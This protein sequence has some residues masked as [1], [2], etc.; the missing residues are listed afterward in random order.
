MKKSDVIKIV[1]GLN[2]AG[3]TVW[4]D[5]GWCVD[6]LVG[7]S[8][9]EHGDLDIAVRHIDEKPVRDWLTAKGFT[10]RPSSDKS[11][12]NYVLGNDVG[13]LV[14]IHVFGFDHEGKHIY[15]VKYPSESLTGRATLGGVE[16]RCIAPEWMFR[17]KTGYAPAPKDIVDVYALAEKYGY[18]IPRTHRSS[19]TFRMA[20]TADLD[21]IMQ[22]DNLKRLEHINKAVCHGE[23]YVA[24][25]N[26]KI[27]GF[28]IL[29][30]KFFEYGF[31]ELLIIAEMRRRQGI[32]G[33]FIE[34]L[35]GQCVTEKLFTSTNESNTPMRGLLCKTG[36]VPCGQIDALDEGD[37]E[38]FFV[39]KKSYK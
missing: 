13:C 26:T 12:W 29:G 16:I 2:E 5:G 8:L 32:G 4:V 19:V 22:I 15:G 11:H 24:E 14:D 39:R 10:D 37:P 9:R 3:V 35:Y 31:I 17:F 38:L 34:Y 30:Y 36:F 20:E 18:E 21:R 1:N 23:C 7:R 25:E 27:I 33:K 6:A 28:A